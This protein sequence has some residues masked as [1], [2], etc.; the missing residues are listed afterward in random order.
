ML[1]W[2]IAA[3]LFVGFTAP[4]IAEEPDSSAAPLPKRSRPTA[5]VPT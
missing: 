5:T 1:R 2:I 4:A 3:A